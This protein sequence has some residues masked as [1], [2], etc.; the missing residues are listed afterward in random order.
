MTDSTLL[1]LVVVVVIAS[2]QM[3]RYTGRW[4]LHPA[5]FWTVELM[6]LAAGVFIL[7]ASFLDFPPQIKNP[8]KGFL[9]LFVVWRIVQ[10]WNER[11]KIRRELAGQKPASK[12]LPPTTGTP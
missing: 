10:N 11:A 6:L 4:I 1:I 9:C 5:V 12:G 8:L 2:S 3:L 7:T